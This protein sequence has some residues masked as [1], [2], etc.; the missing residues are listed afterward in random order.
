MRTASSW[1][2]FGPPSSRSTLA[3][4]IAEQ[5]STRLTMLITASTT[6]RGAIS[7]HSSPGLA[8]TSLW[9]QYSSEQCWSHPPRRGDKSA[10][11]FT[12]FLSVLRCSRPRAP[13]PDDAS[14]RPSRSWH[15]LDKK[16]RPQFILNCK[17]CQ[18]ATRPHQYTTVSAMA[19]MRV[20]FSMC[21]DATR[22]M[23]PHAAITCTEADATIAKRTKA[24]HLSLW[25]HASLA[26]LSG[27]LDSWPD[28]DSQ[29]TAS[30]TL[31]KRTP[32]C[33]LLT[34]A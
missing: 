11:S 22:R 24:P 32:T 20:L 21:A 23:A 13:R 31:G 19:P 28:S 5:P 1:C 17:W 12:G 27:G 9:Q 4:L 6:T 8:R 30:S 26:R 16:G 7:P 2:S 33:G 18:N 29:P 14:P 3:G 25:V 10:T 15:P 34:I